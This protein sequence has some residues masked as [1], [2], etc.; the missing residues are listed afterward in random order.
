MD[1]IK[2][3][4]RGTMFSSWGMLSFGNAGYKRASVSFNPADLQ[5]DLTGKNIIV[6]GGNAG[7]GRC[8]AEDLVKL[9]ATVHIVCRNAE[10]GEKAKEEIESLLKEASVKLWICDMASPQS[11]SEFVKA[12]KRE[13]ASL[14]VLVN[15]AGVLLNDKTFTK[16][17]VESSFACNLLGTYHLTKLLLPLLEQSRG[18]VITISSGGMYSSDLQTTDIAWEK[19]RTWDGVKAYS[20]HKRAQ[21]VLTNLWAEK[22]PNVYFASMHPGWAATPGVAGALPWMDQYLAWQ[23]RTPSQGAD[24]IT[25][26][27]ACR[28]ITKRYPSGT[29]FFD[30]APARQHLPLAGTEASKEQVDSMVNQLED[31]LGK[32]V[33]PLDY[34]M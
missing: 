24:T 30:R 25:W 17:G 27:A 4:I 16:D 15:N 20:E 3:G 18:K 9:H 11:V 22:Y 34:E 14:D 21:V 1:L 5:V 12:Y 8:V 2:N 19:R 10:R 28:D 13:V 29:F 6:T 26:L 32:I 33:G 23:L 31:R 7:L